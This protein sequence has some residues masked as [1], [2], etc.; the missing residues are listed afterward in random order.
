MLAAAAVILS[1]GFRNPDTD[2]CLACLIEHIDGDTAAR[3]PVAADAQPFGSD[4]PVYTDGNT[5]GAVFMKSGVITERPQKELQRLTFQNQLIRHIV[6]Y[7]MGKIRLAR[8][9]AEGSKFRA[10]EAHTIISATMRIG[11]SFQ[12]RLFRITGYR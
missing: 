7:Q 10:R 3:V 2:G 6:D 11:H 12:H 9:W 8:D 1:A 4:F 5:D